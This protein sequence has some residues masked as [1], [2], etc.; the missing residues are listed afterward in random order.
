M[1]CFCNRICPPCTQCALRRKA[2]GHL[3]STDCCQI[4]FNPEEELYETRAIIIQEH[5]LTSESAY[6]DDIIAYRRLKAERTPVKQ[7]GK[8]EGNNEFCFCCCCCF[9]CEE[10]AIVGGILYIV[11]QLC[12]CL[13]TLAGLNSLIE[14]LEHG[15][16][17]C[18]LDRL[19][20]QLSYELDYR[21]RNVN[22]IVPV[23]DRIESKRQSPDNL[24]LEP[25]VY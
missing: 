3:S 12:K 8:R 13:C 4:C 6:A 5:S 25:V 15:V 20:A 22:K 14:N 18:Y 21:A 1:Y 2:L 16:P 19:T 24:E 10:I 9:C 11:A 17:C 7:E 23:K